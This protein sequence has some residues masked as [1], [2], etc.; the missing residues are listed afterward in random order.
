MTNKIPGMVRLYLIGDIDFDTLEDRLLPLAWNSQSE[1]EMD[2]VDLILAE[3]CCVKDGVSD[4]DL[5]RERMAY[6]VGPDDD[7]A[8][9]RER[10]AEHGIR[11]EGN[12]AIAV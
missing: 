8:L 2:A 11:S 12:S 5:F 9:F 4:E 3:I 1:E 6:L 7:D 10:V